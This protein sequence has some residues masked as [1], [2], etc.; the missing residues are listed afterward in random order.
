MKKKMRWLLPMI[1]V[2][3]CAV[4]TLGY[5]YLFVWSDDTTA[6]EIT[7]DTEVL[8]VSVNADDEVLLQGVSAIDDVD[9]DVTTNVLVEGVSNFWGD[10]TVTI[11]YA[12]F[13]AA[14][15][16]S[17]ASRTLK[18]TD[19]KSP[20]FGL[21]NT[22]VLRA[23]STTDILKYVTAKDTIDGDISKHVKGTLVSETTSLSYSGVHQVEFRVTN[24]LG[25]TQ[26]ITLPV[27]VY[28][29]NTYNAT[30]NLGDE[31]LIY[32]KRGAAF[33][34]EEYLKELVVGTVSYSL[35]NQ[36]PPIE[37]LKREQY[38]LLGDDRELE[39]RTY[40]NSYVDPE[41]NEDPFVGIA[42]VTIENNVINTIPGQYTV[43]YL[44]DYEERY[45]GYARL[46]VVVED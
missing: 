33:R 45:V 32:L 41:E 39:V 7:I 6:P 36:N 19:Y 23:G 38:E 43:T 13:D 40:I 16:V 31:Y 15:N 9:G 12:A 37:N 5:T 8:E 1:L 21:N 35:E 46:N 4:V 11:T 30:V 18:Y 25:D 27:E 26:R 20:V 3:L 44:V 34:P 22:L 29:N 14:G 28:E 42:N 2:L 24:S 17:K 10:K